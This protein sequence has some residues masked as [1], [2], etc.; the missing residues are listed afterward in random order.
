M[1][2]FHVLNSP[3]EKRMSD[4]GPPGWLSLLNEKVNPPLGFIGNSEN[5]RRVCAISIPGLLVVQAAL[6]Y[7]FT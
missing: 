3:V 5:Y 7:I 4:R 6:V 2:S 1:L